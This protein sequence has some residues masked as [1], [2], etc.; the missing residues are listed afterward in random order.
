VIVE[1]GESLP[2]SFPLGTAG[3]W[4]PPPQVG[5]GG[6]EPFPTPV[7]SPADVP[8][9]VAGY[10]QP[11]FAS[12]SGTA[13]TAAAMFPAFT[14][15]GPNPPIVLNA[16]QAAAVGATWVAPPPPPLPTTPGVWPI[17]VSDVATIPQ[18]PW[19]PA[20]PGVEP[21]PEEPL[22]QRAAPVSADVAPKPKRSHAKGKPHGRAHRH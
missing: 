16:T 12:G 21:D 2:P 10:S 13:P 4:L 3:T 19:P 8:P 15:A 17:T 5:F 14:A 7:V 11:Q 20:P 1:G 18:L 9:S 22:E 6:N